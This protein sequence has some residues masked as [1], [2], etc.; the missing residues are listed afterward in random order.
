MSKNYN[1]QRA[2]ETFCSDRLKRSYGL[3]PSLLSLLFPT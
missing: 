1:M 3:V 2:V